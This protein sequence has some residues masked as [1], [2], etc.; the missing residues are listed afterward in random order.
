MSE[1]RTQT[2]YSPL[3]SDDSLA[4]KKVLVILPHYNFRDKEYSWLR[5]RLD[6]AGVTTEVASTHLSEAQGRFGT[7]VNPDCLVSFV[8]ANDY[9]AF[10]FVGE[11]AASEYFDNPDILRTL[12]TA[13]AKRKIVA[14]IGA[15]VP[16]VAFTGHLVGRKVTS[17]ES[18]RTRLEELGAYFTGNLVEQDGDI[19]TANGPYG[20]R[21]FADSVVKALKWSSVVTG[22]GRTFLR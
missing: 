2:H 3:A 14:A 17:V 11:E 22:N 13:F 12:E 16:I 5:E 20:T 15:A 19:I 4:G 7:I 6:A 10:I 21:E 9:D 1:I 8:E 18:E